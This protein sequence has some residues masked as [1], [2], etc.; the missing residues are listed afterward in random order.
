MFREYF[1]VLG[2]EVDQE[3]FVV[4]NICP[5]ILG[6]IRYPSEDTANVCVTAVQKLSQN[7]A[8]HMLVTADI[9]PSFLECSTPSRS[10]VAPKSLPAPYAT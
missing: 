4:E 8:Y 6:D 3:L 5:H 2:F 9:R 1:L 7:A 10:P